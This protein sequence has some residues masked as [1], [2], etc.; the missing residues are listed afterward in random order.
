[1][2]CAALLLAAACG[3]DAGQRISLDSGWR[4]H[5]ASNPTLLNTVSLKQWRMK[6]GGAGEADAGTLAKPALDTGSADWTDAKTGPDVFHGTA[7]FAW[8]RA[9]LPSVPGPHRLLRFDSVDDNGTVYLNGRRLAHHNGFRGSFDVLLDSAWQ[10]GGPNVL[11]VLDENTGG[12]GGIM[13][14]VTLGTFDQMLE[15]DTYRPDFNDKNWRVV[16][17][18]HDFVVEGKFSP[19]ANAAHGS[20]PVPTAWYRKT[21]TLSAADRGKN[22][23]IDFDGVYR[24]SLVYLNGHLLGNHKGGYTGFRYDINR[25]AHYGGPNTLAV[26]VDP[27]NSEGWWYEGGGIYRHVWLDMA[28]PRA[29]RAVRHVRQ[30]LKFA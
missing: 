13:G 17:L 26:F 11:A 4:F 7:G 20:L 14:E 16:H 10:E 21:F 29:Y 23:W 18:P 28:N 3:A 6:I 9:I 25:A 12:G 1:M 30:R 8:Y 2:F 24:D 22:V 19:A 15:S 5:L 27:R